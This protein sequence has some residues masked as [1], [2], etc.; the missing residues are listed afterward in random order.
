MNCFNFYSENASKEL[1]DHATTSKGVGDQT[2][3]TLNQCKIDW[4]PMMDQ[5]FIE[6]MLDQVRKGN[7]IGRTFKKK[8][9]VDM[10]ES[11]NARFESH[12]GKV[13]LKNRLNVLRR[14]YCTIN[15]LLAKEGFS[16]DKREQKVVADDQA[17]QKCIRV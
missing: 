16:W 10:I 4:S 1:D 15:V 11:F 6:L 13:V 14:H 12:Y 17:W 5:F 3:P 7:K 8:A 9:W 2:P